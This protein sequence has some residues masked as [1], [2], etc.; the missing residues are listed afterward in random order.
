ML[1]DCYEAM[2]MKSKSVMSYMIWVS[3]CG[4]ASL[5]IH[6]FFGH[7]PAWRV[8]W[9]AIPG[10]YYATHISLSQNH[11]RFIN[12]PGRPTNAIS[13]VLFLFS[14]SGWFCHYPFEA[15]VFIFFSNSPRLRFCHCVRCFEISTSQPA[16]SVR[17][18]QCTKSWIGGGDALKNT[19]IQS[20]V[21]GV[22]LR[23]R[24]SWPRSI[25]ISVSGWFSALCCGVLLHFL[26]DFA[27]RMMGILFFI[28]GGFFV[29]FAQC[30]I[31]FRVA[32]C[33]SAFIMLNVF[34]YHFPNMR[35]WLEVSVL[36]ARK[37]RLSRFFAW[38]VVFTLFSFLFSLS[39]Y[40][41]F[42]GR[43]S[44]Q[45]MSCKFPFYYLFLFFSFIYLALHVYFISPD[46]DRIG[47]LSV[48]SLLNSRIP[49]EAFY[50]A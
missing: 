20:G 43:L 39:T 3:G 14:F 6:N 29:V 12:Y 26:V 22:I 42:F 41:C 23:A 13:F 45:I 2:G 31:N 8:D 28:V 7:L 47:R 10:F 38:F 33:L 5:L 21:K 44:D 1:F 15:S 32:I 40:I 49:N 18:S 46:Y 24:L 11:H 35:V 36:S 4:I 9:L 48:F 34:S 19:R 27:G 37:R 17:W 16:M 25:P 50:P 30:Y